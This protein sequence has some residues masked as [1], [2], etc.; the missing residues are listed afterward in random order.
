M[1]RLSGLVTANPSETAP[2]MVR[3]CLRLI[4]SNFLILSLFHQ[5]IIGGS[6]DSHSKRLA[7]RGIPYTIPFAAVCKVCLAAKLN[8]PSGRGIV[9]TRDGQ[10]SH[11]VNVK[12]RHDRAGR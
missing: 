3:N 2:A 1:K 12:S 11:V 6:A 8:R 7:I 4:F 5:L 9:N 10:V